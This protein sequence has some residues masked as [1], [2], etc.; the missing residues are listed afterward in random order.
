[1]ATKRGNICIAV[2]SEEEFITSSPT[3]VQKS[4]RHSRC[5]DLPMLRFCW[6]VFVAVDKVF[7]RL[8]GT[9]L[10]ELW[11]ASGRR[12]ISSHFVRPKSLAVTCT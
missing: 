7:Q 6:L 8:S 9:T 11:L 12:F 3:A 4:V 1:M 10:L 5:C 2:S